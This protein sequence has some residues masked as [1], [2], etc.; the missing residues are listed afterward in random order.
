MTG[1]LDERLMD[2]Y[3]RLLAC[4]GPQSWWPGDSPFEVIVGA[5]LTQSAAWTGVERAIDNL[6]AAGVLSPAAL[7][8]VPI[9]ELAVLIRPSVYFNAKSRKL[10]AFVEHLGER[11]DDD[12]DAMFRQDVDMLRRELL[13]IH[14]IGEET[15]DDIL[16]YAAGKPVFVID[17]YTRRILGRLGIT[18]PV[19]R[20]EAYQVLFM[21][22]LPRD[23]GLFNEYHALLDRHGV[24]ACHKSSPLCE[25]CCLLAV[26]PTGAAALRSHVTAPN[27]AAPLTGSQARSG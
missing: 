6:K 10:R 17:A 5:I 3:R 1:P 12:L 2:V 13:S 24:E 25:P 9:E 11:Y 23:S 16:L 8:A 14:G 4:Y 20:Y 21:D 18:P 15:A 27:Q 22:S 7:R 19:D 26:C